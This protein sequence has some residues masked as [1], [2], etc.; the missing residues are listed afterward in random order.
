[1]SNGSVKQAL[2]IFCYARPETF[3]KGFFDRDKGVIV[4]I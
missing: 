3:T 2:E 4:L 1:M